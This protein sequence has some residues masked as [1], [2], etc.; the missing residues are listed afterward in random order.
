MDLLI[1]GGRVIDP[2]NGVDRVTDLYLSE[3]KVVSLGRVPDGWGARETTVLNAAGKIVSPGFIDLHM[4]EDPMNGDGTIGLCIFPAM[5]AMGVTTAV[6]GNCGDCTDDPVR[7][8]DTV[9]RH[10]APVNVAMLAGHGYFRTA[11]GASDPYAPADRA[12]TDRI[13][14]G[15]REALKGGCAGVSFGIRY[16]PGTDREELTRAIGAAAGTGKLIAAHVR[17]DAAAV[18]DSID[19]IVKPAAARGLPVQISHIGSMAGFGQMEEVLR[20]LDEARSRGLDLAMDCYPYAAF[21]TSI[22]SATYDNGWLERYSCDYG[23]LEYCGGPWKGQ[24]ATAETFD[25]MRKDCPGCLTV[26]YVMREEEVS[27]A[28]SHPWVCLASDGVLDH[29]NG[30]PRAAGTFPRFLRQCIDRG[31]P[32]SDA[33]RRMT[34]LPASRLGVSARKGHLGVGADADVT[35]F[36][37]ASVADRATFREPL[38]PPVGIETVIVG[39]KIAVR[40]GKIADFSAGR[41]VRI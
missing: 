28:L 18:F 13:A 25:T 3:G 7:Y 30:H 40:D 12:Q 20:R 4:H 27:L 41:S 22:G 5:L 39:G 2:K 19:E 10:G 15:I 9:D 1:A 8:L 35:V 21:S 33:I 37:P 34:A 32:L 14:E 23:V 31:V 26:C 6:G 29:G 16:Y 24:R 11:A 38:L 17:D 36:D